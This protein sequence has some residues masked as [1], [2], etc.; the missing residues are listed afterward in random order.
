MTSVAV[1]PS[2][3]DAEALGRLIDALDGGADGARYI[4]G[5]VRD[6]LL[7]LDPQDIDIAT[8]HAPRE[9]ERRAKAAGLNTWSSASGIAHGTIGVVIGGKTVEVTTLRRDVSTDGRHATV[10]FT[11][12][13]REDAARRD[14]TINAL[15]ADPLTGEVHDYFGGLADLTEGRV[16][17]I[18]DP[19]IRIAED[20]L[21]ILRFFRF[22]ARFG[23]GVPD[24]ASYE[25]CV[26]RAK[27]LMAL[28]RERIA[29][30]LLKLLAVD[31]PVATVE[32]MLAGGLFA[33]VVPEITGSD[34]LAALVAAEHT[35]GIA[36]DG[37]RR[38]AALLPEDER[39][40]EQVGAR[41]KLSNADRK[42]LTLAARPVFAPPEV[43]VYTFGNASATDMALLTGLA[44]RAK[45]ASA[46]QAPRFPLTGGDLIALGLAPGPIVAATLQAVEK[47]WVKEGFPD[48]DRLGAM[49][50]EAVVAALSPG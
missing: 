12:D 9:A 23:K 22:H 4:G 28:S 36:P 33:P 27:D 38:L 41:L 3:A 49:A 30:E 10:A 5:W 6:T 7:G 29:A 20:H 45:I 8:R 18:G 50:R 19:L 2:V 13:W 17:F 47:K 39:I 46:W 37:L 48:R 40:A 16:R 44:D 1:P 14:F 42:R 15:S 11:E 34:R 31:D 43:L 35:A 26:V 32:A 25:A 21:R 24:A